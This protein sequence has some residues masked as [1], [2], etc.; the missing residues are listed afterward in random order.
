MAAIPATPPRR[1]VICGGGVVG[2]CTAYFL[3][4]HAAAPTVPTL[5]EKCAPACGASGKAGG[6]LALDWCDSTPSLSALARASFALHRRLA[7]SLDGAAAYGY[8]PVH[9]L[10]IC[11]PSDA[12]RPGSPP[13]PLLPGWVDPAASAA[14]PRE[15]GTPETTA[16]V[17]PGL[18]TK[19]VLAASGAEVVVGEVERVVVRDDCRVA[20]VAVKGRDGVVDADAVVLALGPWSGRLDVVREV[21]HVSGIKAH[22]IVLRPRE[23]EKITPHA[24][25]LSYQPAPGAKMLDPEVYPRPT[26]EVYVCGMSKDEDAPDDPAT[27][28]GEPDSIAMLHKIAGRVSSHLRTEEGAKVVAE[29]ACYLPCS[30]D[31]L[32]I[33]G[34]MPGVKGCYIATGHSCWGILN[35]PATGAALAEL[36]LDGKAK[37]VDLEAFSPARFLKRRSRR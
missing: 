36:I 24:L 18:F 19:A 9:T 6:F 25:F 21:C 37:T 1:V 23:P 4:T 27:I 28:T 15:L 8:R 31:G 13:H 5:I 17:H 7:A 20:G 3:S 12:P 14:P 33:I 16:Q 35:A 11:V 34:E 29:Q 2:S 26:G 10:S 30:T 22:S 32:P